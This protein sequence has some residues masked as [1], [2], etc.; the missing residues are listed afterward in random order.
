MSYIGD[1]LEA[2][3]KL[4]EHNKKS[5]NI[6][7]EY[8]RIIKEKNTIIDNNIKECL[9]KIKSL[10]N[11]SDNKEES[12]DEFDDESYEENYEEIKNLRKRLNNLKSGLPYPHGNGIFGFAVV[13][14]EAA[15]NINE[16]WE[17]FMWIR[18][19][20]GYK[21]VYPKYAIDYI[22]YKKDVATSSN[23]MKDIINQL[24]AQ[25]KD[26]NEIFYDDWL[27]IIKSYLKEN[28]ITIDNTI[29]FRP[30]LHR[31]L[32]K[33][34]EDDVNYYRFTKEDIE[35]SQTDEEAEEEH[36]I[37]LSLLKKNEDCSL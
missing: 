2:F 7:K 18:T 17:H 36:Q 1:Y 20:M 14:H 12:E 5:E 21:K 32:C 15:N 30:P 13:L 31:I 25:K 33:D 23:Y 3:E 16:K 35:F 37:W 27:E 29:V 34:R 24:Y 28:S 9:E 26:P 11:K 22:E 4:D 8:D 6:L 10:R 19:I